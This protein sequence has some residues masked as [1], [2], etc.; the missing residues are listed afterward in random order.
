[1]FLTVYIFPIANEVQQAKTPCNAS[2]VAHPVLTPKIQGYLD[3]LANS[4]VFHALKVRETDVFGNEIFFG[5]QSYET[6]IMLKTKLLCA[7]LKIDDMLYVLS[8][9]M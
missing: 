3:A 4:P 1:M 9:K 2:S 7:D 5:C 8:P 6:C